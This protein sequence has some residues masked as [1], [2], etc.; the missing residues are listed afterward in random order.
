MTTT[1]ERL[2]TGPRMSRIVRHNVVVYLCGLTA[3]SGVGNVTQQTQEALARVGGLLAVAGTAK[4][5]ILTALI[6]LRSMSDFVSMNKVSEAYWCGP[7][8]HHCRGSAHH[9]RGSAGSART[10]CRNIHRRAADS[11]AASPAGD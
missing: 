9:C 5:R 2:E 6:H 8:A 1:I 11:A 10:T 7:G 3:A 4:T